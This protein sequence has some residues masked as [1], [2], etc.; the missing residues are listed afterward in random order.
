MATRRR[1]SG[2]GRCL[3]FADPAQATLA[4]LKLRVD[5]V[6]TLVWSVL[7]VFLRVGFLGAP[8]QGLDLRLIEQAGQRPLP[9]RTVDRLGRIIRAPAFQID[10]A[11]ELADGREA[12]GGGRRRHAA[13]RQLAQIGAH[14]RVVRIL[15]AKT[16]TLE[17]ATV[18]GQIAPIGVQGVPGRAAL[19]RHHFEED[20]YP[21]LAWHGG[22]AQRSWISAAATAMAR[23]SRSRPTRP[24]ARRQAT[25]AS[26]CTSSGRPFSM[27]ST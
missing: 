8:H 1:P 19:D 21:G 4:K 25:S 24:S 16:A 14:R 5:L 2:P 17:K 13:S 27:C 10:K 22:R 26:G 15:R 23:A 3:R 20:F 11:M 12:A 9:A 18:I 6:S 7:G